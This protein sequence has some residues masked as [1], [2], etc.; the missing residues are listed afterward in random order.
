MVYRPAARVPLATNKSIDHD[1]AIPTWLAKEGTGK[2]KKLADSEIVGDMN[3]SA[4]KQ[5]ACKSELKD[6]RAWLYEDPESK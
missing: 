2:T 5:P 3:E 4:P 1:H 6:P